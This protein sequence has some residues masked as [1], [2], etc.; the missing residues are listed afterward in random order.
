MADHTIILNTT[1]PTP[2]EQQVS[3]GDK[4][5]FQNNMSEA[6]T[7]SFSDN[8]PFIPKSDIVIQA[9]STSPNKNVNGAAGTDTYEYTIPGVKR[10]T[11][12]GT[13]KV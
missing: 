7:V 8:S 13:I 11:R 12:S 3:A 6:T 9:N 2:T 4:V 10:G 1:G 5:A